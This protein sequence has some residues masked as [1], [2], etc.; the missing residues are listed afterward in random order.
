MVRF[1]LIAALL[2]PCALAQRTLTAEDQTAAYTQVRNV[3]QAFVPR[4]AAASHEQA[5]Q[6]LLDKMQH[7]LNQCKLSKR[8]RSSY[9][10]SVWPK[11]K[12]YPARHSG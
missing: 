4:I 9:P 5:R 11:P 3:L 12:T 1:I 7:Y 2:V 10:R 8:R 6:E